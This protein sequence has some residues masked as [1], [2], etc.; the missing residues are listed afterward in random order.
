MHTAPEDL[1]A[2]AELLVCDCEEGSLG[3]LVEQL[4]A[5]YQ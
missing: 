4:E 3:D 1:K 2:L 5:R